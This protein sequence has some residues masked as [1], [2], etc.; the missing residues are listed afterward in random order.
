MP[1]KR[2]LDIRLLKKMYIAGPSTDSNSESLEKAET[3]SA[4]FR[5]LYSQPFHQDK[6]R[7]K[8]TNL[9]DFDPFSS[10][11]RQSVA[12]CKK[13]RRQRHELSDKCRYVLGIVD[14]WER[15]L[16]LQAPIQTQEGVTMPHIEI[17][18]TF[19]DGIPEMAKEYVKYWL[20]NSDIVKD[21]YGRI[22]DIR[23][24]DDETHG[25]KD[26]VLMLVPFENT[27]TVNIEDVESLFDTFMH[28][29]ETVAN[30]IKVGNVKVFS[31]LKET[32]ESDALGFKDVL[33]VKIIGDEVVGQDM[34]KYND[35][36]KA[37]TERQKV[38]V[39]RLFR[40]AGEEID[41]D[42]L[43]DEQLN[44]LEGLYHERKKI[45][46]EMEE[47]ARLAE[48][49]ERANQLA[50][51]LDAA[52]ASGDVEKYDELVRSNK[53]RSD[54]DFYRNLGTLKR[55]RASVQQNIFNLNNK[56]NSNLKKV[57]GI[58]SKEEQKSILTPMQQE[59]NAL[60]AERKQKQR[61][62]KEKGFNEKENKIVGDAFKNAIA[63]DRMGSKTHLNPFSVALRAAETAPRAL[64]AVADAK[65]KKKELDEERADSKKEQHMEYIKEEMKRLK[66]EP[67]VPVES[68]PITPPKP[69]YASNNAFTSGNVTGSK[70]RKEKND[71]N[72]Q[73]T[74]DEFEYG[75]KIADDTAADNEGANN[76]PF[77]IKSKSRIV[78]KK[79]S[80]LSELE[81]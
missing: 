65:E 21:P 51:E 39:K 36:N 61:E 10:E 69:S 26:Y 28:R 15:L 71:K 46:L 81:R 78:I 63:P 27:P 2:N 25:K 33:P 60:N 68:S 4:Y 64:F 49:Y 52:R 14:S 53:I 38:K 41:L 73:R 34:K 9:I 16:S 45:I 59:L 5:R 66:D 22:Y 75:K 8:E 48:E 35:I 67:P 17:S 1:K 11:N 50:R 43:T 32:R 3:N 29:P 19:G 6:E 40:W 7:L 23:S 76:N 47:E 80:F 54:E 18:I 13:H 56:F 77:I 70:G 58:F 31:K 44:A 37:L 57:G 72:R 24:I 20:T 55:N 74:I 12:N 79:A 30:D 62:K 42:S